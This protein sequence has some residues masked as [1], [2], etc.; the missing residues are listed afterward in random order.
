[1]GMGMVRWTANR[2]ETSSDPFAHPALFYRSEAEFLA[3][4]VPFVLDGLAA[5]EPVA[6]AVPPPNLALLRAELGAATERVQL[7]DMTERGRNPGRI[8]AEVLHA[9]ADPHP[10]RNVRIIGEPIWPGRTALEYDACVHHEALSTCP[11]TADE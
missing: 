2:P 9:A 1:M 7:V 10:D 11:S 3:G 6:V 8:L 5:G 4:T